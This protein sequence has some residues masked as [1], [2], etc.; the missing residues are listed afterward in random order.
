MSSIKD[1]MP[2]QTRSVFRHD[3]QANLAE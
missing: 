1:E 2:G 3:P